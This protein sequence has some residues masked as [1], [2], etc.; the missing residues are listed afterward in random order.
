M[1]R[2]RE[3]MCRF[4]ASFPSQEGVVAGVALR[5]PD[6]RAGCCRMLN[7]A[8]GLT[9]GDL[10]RR[11]G[12]R[13]LDEAFLDFLGSGEADLKRRLLEGRNAPQSLGHEAVSALMLALAPHLEDFLADVFCIRAEARELAAGHH[14]LAPLYA[15]KRLFVQRR[16]MRKFTPAEAES[17]DGEALEAQLAASLGGVFD[18]LAF[19]TA[20]TRWEEAPAPVWAR[21]SSARF[22][23]STLTAS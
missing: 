6:A 2:T 8:F 18:E 19:A 7:N 15:C 5:F 3:T 11:E 4:A 21:C 14:A 13:R 1:S 23:R 22:A 20:V 17:F 16:A 9:I 12:L 10:Y